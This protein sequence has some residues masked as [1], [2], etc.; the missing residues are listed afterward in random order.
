MKFTNT[1]WI[2]ETITTTDNRLKSEHRIK[3]GASSMDVACDCGNVWHAVKGNQ[4]GDI[5]PDGRS[6]IVCA[7]CGNAENYL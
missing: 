1:M 2:Y 7:E 6:R 4:R 5:T 3:I